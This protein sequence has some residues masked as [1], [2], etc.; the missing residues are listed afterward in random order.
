MFVAVGRHIMMFPAKCQN[1][2]N[3]VGG[4]YREKRSA[5]LTHLSEGRH[6]YF[7]AYCIVCTLLSQWEFLPWEIRVAFPKEK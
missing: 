2:Q 6:L 7:L 1:L 5:S 3:D 4:Q